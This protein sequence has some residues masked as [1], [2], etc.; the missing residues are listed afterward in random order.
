VS[1]WEGAVAETDSRALH[2]RQRQLQIGLALTDR[3]GGDFL[4][5]FLLLHLLDDL[6]VFDLGN[7]LTAGHAIAE[8]DEY[9]LQ[10]SCGPRRDRHLASPI[11]LPTTLIS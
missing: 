7:A 5:G 11:R 1:A 3:G 9:I 2:V 6:E 10:T 4:R 8:P